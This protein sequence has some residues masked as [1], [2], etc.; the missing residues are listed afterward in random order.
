MS[1][2]S[3]RLTA[4]WDARERAGRRFTRQSRP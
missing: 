1:C 4:P 3:L 2:F